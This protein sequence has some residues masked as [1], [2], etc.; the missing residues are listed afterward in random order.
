MLLRKLQ[1]PSQGSV[2]L[3]FRPHL[4]HKPQLLFQ[5]ACQFHLGPTSPT[6]TTK[7]PRHTC[8]GFSG[9]SGTGWPPTSPYLSPIRRSKRNTAVVADDG[10]NPEAAAV[11]DMGEGGGGCALHTSCLWNQSQTRGWTD[12]KFP[13]GDPSTLTPPPPYLGRRFPP[14]WVTTTQTLRCVGS[15]AQGEPHIRCTAR[16]RPGVVDGGEKVSPEAWQPQLTPTG[17]K[18]LRA[19]QLGEEKDMTFVNDLKV[20]M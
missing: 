16:V 19:L 3:L 15:C 2:N 18:E 8:T 13:W 11:T 12:P 4:P 7:T 9:A 14:W 20:S 5:R 6:P 1:E 10:L 17:P